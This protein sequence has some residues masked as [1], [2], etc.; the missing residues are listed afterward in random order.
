MVPLMGLVS[1]QTLFDLLLGQR[2]V[3]VR[4]RSGDPL[5]GLAGAIKDNDGQNAPVSARARSGA[6]AIKITRHV[7]AAQIAALAEVTG[8]VGTAPPA[9]CK[10]WRSRSGRCWGVRRGLS[11]TFAAR[12]ILPVA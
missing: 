6:G 7:P 5:R 3:S 1:D 12:A 10:S 4:A 8:Y 9:A 2:P 11:K